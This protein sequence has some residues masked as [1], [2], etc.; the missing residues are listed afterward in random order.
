MIRYRLICT[1][2]HEFEGWFRNSADYDEQAE[3]KLVSCPH[4]GSSKVE[5]ALMAPNVSSK[6]RREGVEGP[7]ARRARRSRDAGADASTQAAESETVTSTELRAMAAVAPEAAAEFAMQRAMLT[8][9]RKARDEV[10]SKSEN[11]GEKFAE[12]A[13]KIHYEEAEGRAIH[14]QATSQEARALREEG[15]EFHP[16]PVFPDDQN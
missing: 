15:I 16:I 3:R 8:A 7:A 2:K 13:R 1:R 4:C 6:T 12:E 9:M 10:L 5:K 14:G 11:V